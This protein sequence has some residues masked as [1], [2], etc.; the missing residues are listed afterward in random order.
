MFLQSTEAQELTSR[1][2]DVLHLIDS[3]RLEVNR[4]LDPRRKVE[5]GQ[6]LTPMP[7][8]QL[9]ASMLECHEP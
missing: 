3:W 1:S 9:M 6:F 5:L 8:A 4:Q 7:V 2:A